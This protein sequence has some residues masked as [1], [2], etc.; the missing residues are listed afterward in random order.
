MVKQKTI[1]NLQREQIKIGRA[2]QS[3][4]RKLPNNKKMIN[5]NSY[6][7]G[8]DSPRGRI[9]SVTP[10]RLTKYLQTIWLMD[11]QGHFVGRANYEGKTAAKNISKFGYDTT[12]VVRDTKRYKRV[13]GRTRRTR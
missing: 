1:H 2:V 3:Y 8:Y 9:H 11:K 12:T 5:I 13:F 4:K 7:Q 10:D 6:V